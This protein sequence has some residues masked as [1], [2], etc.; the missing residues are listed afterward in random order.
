MDIAIKAGF[1]FRSSDGEYLE[2]LSGEEI[3]V[4]SKKIKDLGKNS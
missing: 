3:K 1:T 4:P 2:T